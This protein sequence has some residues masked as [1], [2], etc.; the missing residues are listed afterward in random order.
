MEVRRQK[1][2]VRK[3]DYS[4]SD[5]RLLSSDF[6][7]RLENWCF[8]KTSDTLFLFYIIAAKLFKNV[9]SFEAFED[10]PLLCCA[11]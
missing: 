11:G 9:D 8:W 3:I 5:F 10:V 1:S 7:Y 4:S 2:E 6:T